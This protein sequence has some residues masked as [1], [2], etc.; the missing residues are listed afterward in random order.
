[1]NSMPSEALL[2]EA[3]KNGKKITRNGSGRSSE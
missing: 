1:M 2:E 3:L